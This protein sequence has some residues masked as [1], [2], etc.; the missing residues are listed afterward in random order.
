MRVEIREARAEDIAPLAER[1]RPAD[2]DEVWAAHGHTPEQ[3][4][5]VSLDASTMAWTGLVD[6]EPVCMFGVGPISILGGRGAPW[7]L[8]TDKIERWPRTFLR[9]CRRCVKAMLTVYP[10]LEN[11]VDDRNEV[12]KRWLRWLGFEMGQTV[13]L[14]NGTGFRYFRMEDRHV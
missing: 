2:R 1:M 12:S 13:T 5:Q 9:R 6:G 10:T 8:G 7:L 3:A 11:F 14:P 4:L